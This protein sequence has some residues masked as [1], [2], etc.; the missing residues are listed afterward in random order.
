MITFDDADLQKVLIAATKQRMGLILVRPKNKHIEKA[1]A[2]QKRLI[3]SGTPPDQLQL[4][5]VRTTYETAT[6]GVPDLM[7]ALMRTLGDE[8]VKKT[9]KFGSAEKLLPPYMAP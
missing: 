1:I 7:A 8:I 4:V 9:G 3:E 6:I 2:I 5:A